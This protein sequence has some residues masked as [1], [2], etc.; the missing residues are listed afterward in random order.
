MN[1]ANSGLAAWTSPTYSILKSNNTLIG[2]PVTIDENTWLGSE[3]YL[4]AII[5]TPVYSYVN[6]NL[7]RKLAGY[8]TALPIIVGWIIIIFAKSITYLYIGRAIQGFSFAGVYVFFALYVAKISEDDIRGAL[9][10]LRGVSVHL[11]ILFILVIGPYLTVP[12]TGMVCLSLPLLFL[13]LFFWLPESPMFLLGKGKVEE[14]LN[15]YKWL[16]GGDAGLAQEEM[17]KLER[18]F[19][20]ET[21]KFGFKQIIN[22]RETRKALVISIGLVMTMSFSGTAVLLSFSSNLLAKSGSSFLD[23]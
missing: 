15:S 5:I 14:A 13:V 18:V 17:M 12:Q 3:I 16:R 9:G 4:G 22:T 2:R 21:Q 1:A 20:T 11:G 19:Q 10:F 7:G 8:L 6:Q 23:Y